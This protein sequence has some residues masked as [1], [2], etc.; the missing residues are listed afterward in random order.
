MIE[1]IQG[2]LYTDLQAQV[3]AGYCPRCGGAVYRPSLA[4][5]R[6]ERRGL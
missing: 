3:P 1:E 6:C 4:C 2:T 5:L